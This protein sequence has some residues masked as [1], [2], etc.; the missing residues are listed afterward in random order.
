MSSIRRLGSFA[1]VFV[2]SPREIEQITP[3]EAGFVMKQLVPD[4]VS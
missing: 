4:S 2:P 3:A 1:H